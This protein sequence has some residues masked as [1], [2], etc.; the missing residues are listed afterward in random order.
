MAMLGPLPARKALSEEIED[1]TYSI[2]MEG[3]TAHGLEEAVR[4]ALRGEHGSTFFP[5]P[6]E[7]SVLYDKAMEH[8]VSMRNRIARQQQIER[9]R[10]E[11]APRSE[12]TPEAKARVAA[13]TAAFHASHE[14]E[15][16][17]NLEAERAEIRARYGMTADL[18]AQIPNA[19]VARTWRKAG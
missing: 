16:D 2:V 15:K 12:P 7:L 4:A 17:S 13:L 3:M 8:H 18:V 10:R 19:E 14:R 5:S 9:E 1:A 6:P 11:H